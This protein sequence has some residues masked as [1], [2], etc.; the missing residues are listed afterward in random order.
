MKSKIFSISFLVALV[1]LFSVSE[2]KADSLF[3]D[4]SCIPGS[5]VKNKLLEK[6]F[7]EGV[8]SEME[9]VQISPMGNVNVA[10]LRCEDINAIRDASSVIGLALMPVYAALNAPG[11]KGPL[12]AELA[13]LGLTVSGPAVLGVTVIGS[14]GVATF[15]I[16]MK[17]TMADCEREA[18]E[19][20]KN[21]ILRELEMRYRLP[22]TPNTT[23]Q[24]VK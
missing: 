20:L 23:L 9:L 19:K 21:E 1:C 6:S 5:T 15:Y 11:V 24:T 2:V 17:K 16:V 3:Y 12:V 18:K 10:G 14:V 13:A 4:G 22:S 7:D 8:L